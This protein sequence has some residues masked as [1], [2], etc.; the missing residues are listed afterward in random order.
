MPTNPDC[1]STGRHG[2]EQAYNTAGCRCPDARRAA[3][4]SRTLRRTA[5]YPGGVVDSTG[6][7]RRIEALMSIGW[8]KTDI[9][10]RLGVSDR[11]VG[12]YRSQPRV[13]RRT[14]ATV[15]GLYDALSET[16]GPSRMTAARSRTMGM[17]PPI[18][19][20]DDTIDDPA[21]QPWA[22]LCEDGT[23]RHGRGLATGR[24]D[25]RGSTPAQRAVWRE[26]RAVRRQAARER[27][28]AE[29]EAAVDAYISRAGVA[30]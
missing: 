25:G 4:R 27:D 17:V 7:R 30:S 20:D 14:A 23:V 3:S 9:G 6:T 28:A 18:G 10:G 15:R 26:Q 24:R 29:S 22:V 5:T 16:P 13:L 8:R 19:W 21:A 12:Q 11:T 1:P 2:T